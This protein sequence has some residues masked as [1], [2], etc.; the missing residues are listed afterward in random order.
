MRFEPQ[1]EEQIAANKP[2]TGEFEVFPPGEYAFEIITANEGPSKSSQYSRI[3]LNIKIFKTDGTYT[4]VNDYLSAS[5]AAAFKIRNCAE[6]CGLLDKYHLGELTVDDFL[7]KQGFV[8]VSVEP[9][10]TEYKAKNKVVTY[11]VN[12]SV[13]KKEPPKKVTPNKMPVL[14]DM[15]DDIPF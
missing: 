7:R 1:T 8:K 14:N 4:W 9:E 10:T 11:I 3:A 15:D 12:K 13:A 5:P 2:V 6:A